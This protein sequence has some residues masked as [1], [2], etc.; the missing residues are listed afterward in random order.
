VRHACCVVKSIAS[1]TLLT[2]VIAAVECSS[3]DQ[4]SDSNTS[5]CHTDY[6]YAHIAI[7]VLSSVTDA[8][9]ATAKHSTLVASASIDC[10]LQR[11]ASCAL[12]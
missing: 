5:V 10:V 12:L 11:T 7:A 4:L 2:A 6:S 3:D 8:A 1:A 9:A